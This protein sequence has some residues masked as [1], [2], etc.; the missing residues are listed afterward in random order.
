MFKVRGEL[1]EEDTVDP[2]NQETLLVLSI[3]QNGKIKYY[4][5]EC[6]KIIGYYRNEVLNKKFDFLIPDQYYDQ[7]KKML[8]SVK[9]D[10][11]INDFKLPWLTKEGQEAFASWNIAPVGKGNGPI[12]SIGLVGKLIDVK[13]QPLKNVRSK[14][15]AIPLVKKHDDVMYRFGNKRIFLRTDPNNNI[16]KMDEFDDVKMKPLLKM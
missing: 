2:Q 5:K 3:D 14:E 7:W 6:E 12:E 15:N 9:Q 11:Q 16:K 13:D 8:D 10:K 4:N 1:K